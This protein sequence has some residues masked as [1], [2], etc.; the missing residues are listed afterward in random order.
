MGIGVQF[1]RFEVGVPWV[2]VVVAL[3][4]VPTSI[5]CSTATL[6][7][8]ILGNRDMYPRATAY[9]SKLHLI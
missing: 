9:P 8:E 5:G 2:E 4:L 7:K 3:E 6:A 1:H